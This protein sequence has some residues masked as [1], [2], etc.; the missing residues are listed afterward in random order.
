[1]PQELRHWTVHVDAN[2]TGDEVKEGAHCA[3]KRDSSDG[4]HRGNCDC[5]PLYGHSFWI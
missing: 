4:F 1:M 2:G 5:I 3:V